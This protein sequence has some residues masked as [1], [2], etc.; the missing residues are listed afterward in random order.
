MKQELISIIIPVYNAEKFLKDTIKTVNEQTY[1]NWELIFVNDCSTDNSENIIN[2]YLSDK[3]KLVN[4]DKNSGTAMARNAGIKMAK[5][6]YIAFLDADDLWDKKKLEKQIEFMEKKE[7]AFSFTGYEFAD[8]KGIPNGKK[9]YIPL[10][11]TY[12]DALKNTTISTITVMFNMNKLTKE[13]I[14]MP[15]VKNEDTAT[16]WKILRHGYVAYGLNQILSFYRRSSKTRSSNK[17]KSLRNTWI[18]YRKVEQLSMLTSIYNFLYYVFN[19]IKR[20]IINV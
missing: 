4:L 14:Y 20:R 7:C 16:W 6:T 1:K 3:I 2:Q 18:L 9:V 8:E 15:N 13:E 11:M 5:G 19:A 12:K 17:L 10:E